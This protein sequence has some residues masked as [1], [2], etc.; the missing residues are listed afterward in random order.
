MKFFISRKTD[1][2][3]LT[4][5]QKEQEEKRMSVFSLIVFRVSC[6]YFNKRKQQ[7]RMTHYKKNLWF[8]LF[9]NKQQQQNPYALKWFKIINV[10][11]HW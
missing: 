6:V 4:D 5:C 3:L 8:K 2:I 7:N 9:T 10:G 1:F 11:F